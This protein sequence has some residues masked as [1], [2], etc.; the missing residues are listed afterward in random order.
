MNEMSIKIEQVFYGR[1]QFGYGIL[2]LSKGAGAF[3]DAV[4]S[5]CESIGSPDA[6]VS[7]KPFLVNRIFGDYCLMVC[8]QPGAADSG[9]RPTVF[10]HVLI[11]LA[12]ELTV[13]GLDAFV[14]SDLRLFRNA[15]DER[16][17]ALS[18]EAVARK[19]TAT[20]PFRI[21]F[22]AVVSVREPDSDLI[23][24]L[25][26]SGS[27]RRSWATYAFQPMSGF[28]LYALNSRS[29]LP[30]G[31][32]C[33]DVNGN[34]LSK[35]VSNDKGTTVKTGK[36][37]MSPFEKSPL[38]GV[39]LAVNAVLIVI[40]A[41][42]LMRR[43][44]VQ[45][46]SDIPPTEDLQ[47][48]AEDS[49]RQRIADLEKE[50]GKLASDKAQLEGKLEQAK[51]ELAKKDTEL[52]KNGEAAK[53][54]VSREQVIGELKAKFDECGG[55]KA[56]LKDLQGKVGNAILLKVKPYFQLVNRE[57]LDFQSQGKD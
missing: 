29:S 22:P 30:W 52:A 56:D 13:A 36:K 15:A 3:E 55:K 31:I 46:G 23:R 37:Q 47:A 44:S 7:W 6:F 5:L 28:D 42:L 21:Q 32:A 33:Y 26:G 35:V 49:L 16:P 8:V 19:P 17:E 54:L 20:P 51:I 43:P 45:M 27:T 2:A 11:G 57:I 40:C 50:N 24:A 12:S 53:E 38:F 48:V 14:L 10:C 18:V 1:G 34:V 25:L 39:S 9:G 4:R 41:L